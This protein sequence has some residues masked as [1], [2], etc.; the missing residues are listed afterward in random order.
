MKTL[1][2]RQLLHLTAVALLVYAVYQL[3]NLPEFGL[4]GFLGISTSSWVTL[5]IAVAIIHQVYV[6]FCWRTEL[7][8]KLLSQIM[9]R[10]AFVLYAAGFTVLIVLRPILIFILG[11]SNRGSLPIDPILGYAVSAI[12]VIPDLYLMYSVKTYFGFRRAF[13]LDHFDPSVRDLPLVRHGIFRWSPNAMYVFGFMV[14][15][16]PAFLFQSLAALVVA[17]FSHIYIWVHF[18]VT[19][20]PDMRRIYG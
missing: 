5:T 15:W 19:E 20:R 16:V 2:E 8:W 17:A 6:W 13:G 18:Y 3:R 9:G 11:W 7:E 12:L 4:G 1:F 14:L 10:L